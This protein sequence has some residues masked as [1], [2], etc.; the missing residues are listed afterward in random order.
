M[1]AGLKPGLEPTRGAL[2]EAD[3]SVFELMTPLVTVI[4]WQSSRSG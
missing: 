2:P 3:I 1:T 4:V